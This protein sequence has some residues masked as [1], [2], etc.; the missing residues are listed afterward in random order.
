MWLLF[1]NLFVFT[2]N[3]ILIEIEMVW[4]ELRRNK[5]L[6]Y[7]NSITIIIFFFFLLLCPA[8]ILYISPSVVLINKQL[9]PSLLFTVTTDILSFPI[10][11]VSV[12]AYLSWFEFFVVSHEIHHIAA[13]AAA[14]CDPLLIYDW[15]RF[16]G[17][18]LLLS[19][20]SQC[21]ACCINPKMCLI[22][23]NC[24]VYYIQSDTYESLNDVI[25]VKKQVMRVFPDH[26][27]LYLLYT[28]KRWIIYTYILCHHI[29]FVNV[30][31]RCA[32]CLKISLYLHTITYS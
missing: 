3:N 30:F 12:C 16:S 25:G 2:Y 5:L 19:L 1:N 15:H 31:Q 11:S 18:N 17:L 29:S 20:L 10:H 6:H 13:A 26:Q 9:S 27:V 32:F 8:Y 24:Y 23:N 28:W 7:L 14:A 4:L 21:V 22:F